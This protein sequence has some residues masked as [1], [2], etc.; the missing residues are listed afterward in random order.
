M[1]DGYASL[2]QAEIEAIVEPDSV[3]NDIGWESMAFIYS[4]TDF[5]NFGPSSWQ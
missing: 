2:S 4:W 1:A 3:G 5:G